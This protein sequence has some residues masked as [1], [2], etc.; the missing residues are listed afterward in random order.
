MN[1][2]DHF[3]VIV[4]VGVCAT[5]LGA[6][7]FMFAFGGA[8]MGLLDQRFENAAPVAIDPEGVTQVALGQAIVESGTISH[9]EGAP[10]GLTQ[11]R[12]GGAIV[13]AVRAEQA[14]AGLMSYFR[15]EA[16]ESLYRMQGMIQEKAGRSVVSA[17]RRMWRDGTTRMWRDGT[18]ESAQL[19][20]IEMLGRI[21]AGMILSEQAAIPLREE[22]LGWTVVGRLL[23]M[24]GYRADSQ[25]QLG[26]AVRDAGVMAARLD[27]D[28][29]VAQ[30]SLGSAVLVASVAQEAAASG[31]VPSAF[32]VS[33]PGVSGIQALHEIPYPAGVILLAGLFVMIWGLR[34][35]AEGGHSLPTYGRP[36]AMEDEYRKTG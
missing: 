33:T 3:D 34:S 29:P 27:T 18:T 6:G 36:R 30:E 15:D 23:A 1:R 25:Q 20:F 12:L 16:R 14:R 17:S 11:G 28:R 9:L 24:N 32:A 21:K 4:A 7:I 31:N 22:F 19:Q 8:P 13:T 2:W 35:V 5:M 10:W 26:S